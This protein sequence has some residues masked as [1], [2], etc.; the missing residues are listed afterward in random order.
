M[1]VCIRLTKV[2]QLRLQGVDILKGG[3]VEVGLLPPGQT[4]GE[5]MF[6]DEGLERCLDLGAGI[7]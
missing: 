7:S 2:N 4:K 1:L 5:K 3:G 6:Q